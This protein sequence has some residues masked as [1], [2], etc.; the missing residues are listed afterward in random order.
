MD[1]EK[2]GRVRDSSILYVSASRIFSTLSEQLTQ[3]ISPSTQLS[4]PD[5]PNLPN[6]PTTR[7]QHIEPNAPTFFNINLE[8][9][10]RTLYPKDLSQHYQPLTQTA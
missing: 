10:T 3:P 2:T 6:L 8:P 9:Y 1:T 5:L 4:T 7:Q